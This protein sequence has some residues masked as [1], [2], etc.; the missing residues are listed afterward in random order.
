IKYA[1][2]KNIPFLGLCFG[3]QL[4]VVEFARN[5]CRLKHAHSTE[6]DPNTPHPV[7]D[8][9]PEQIKLIKE[10]KYG[11]TMRLGAHTILI[12]RNTLAY[13]LYGRER[14][15][16]RFRHRYEINPR[17]VDLLEQHG[18][19]FSGTTPDGKIM[20]IGELPDHRFFIGTQFHPEFTS[21]F[22]K[23]NP[24]FDG[25]IKASKNSRK[26]VTSLK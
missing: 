21:R 15:V 7:I 10:S 16:E 4:A 5:V 14:V 11:A 24:L 22:M 3:F 18:F 19:L 13:K 23:P 12:K 25:F 26:Y 8:L 17:Y 1:R 9:L 2:E 20:Q 6:I